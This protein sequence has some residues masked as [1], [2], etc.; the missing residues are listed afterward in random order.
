MSRT[1]GRTLAVLATLVATPLL[2]ASAQQRAAPIAR[3]LAALRPE[4][5]W[6]PL[7]FLSDDLL[8]GR[9][10]GARGGEIAVQYI[11]SEFM[12]LGLEP[13]G[14]SGTW[15]QHVPIVT[16]NPTAT[17]DYG[18]DAR[19]LRFRQDFVAWSEQVPP[20]SAA[21]SAAVEAS[22]E[23]VFV[24]FGITAPQYQWDDYKGADLRGKIL[25]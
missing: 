21:P 2:H 12:A 9:G 6:A 24:G 14:D 7:R 11:A 1:I 20:Q 3:A 4:R 23:L 17:M 13:A 16:Q 19:P 10:T 5:V 25:L 18:A 22:G 15:F 8:E